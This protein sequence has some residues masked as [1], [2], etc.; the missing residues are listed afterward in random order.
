L[1]FFAILLAL[2]I[3]LFALAARIPA[4]LPG[5]ILLAMAVGIFAARLHHAGP[6]AFPLGADLAYAGLT[7][8]A[9]LLLLRPPRSTDQGA[10]T[11]RRRLLLAASPFVFFLAAG[12]ILHEVEEV[13]VVRTFDEAGGVHEARLWVVDH[14]GRPWVVTGQETEHARRIRANPRVQLYRAGAASCRIAEPVRGRETIVAMLERR[15]Q[16]YFVQRLAVAVGVWSG[17]LTGIEETAVAIGFAP[18]PGEG[19]QPGDGRAPASEG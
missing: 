4:R 11:P 15:H 13:V 12:A 16:K 6:Y 8:L 2:A 10:G 17:D 5:A 7:A 18:C 1:L 9:A 3:L 19:Q 14:E